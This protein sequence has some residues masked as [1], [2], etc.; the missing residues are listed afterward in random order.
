MMTEQQA[1]RSL[2]K[3]TRRIWRAVRAEFGDEWVARALERR[4]W[5]IDKSRNPQD[6]AIRLALSSLMYVHS[7]NT[8]G[9]AAALALAHEYDTR[10]LR[11]HDACRL[12]FYRQR[13]VTQ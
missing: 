13:K 11:Y 8:P 4:R 5:H 1:R 9:H 3:T 6:P 12:R 7:P 10:R 2:A